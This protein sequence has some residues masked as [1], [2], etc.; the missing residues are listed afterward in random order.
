LCHDSSFQQFS[1]LPAS[2]KPFFLAYLFKE[3]LP[4]HSLI[5]PTKSQESLLESRSFFES[6]GIPTF[7]LP[8]YDLLPYEQGNVTSLILEDRVT[9]LFAL[10]KKQRGIYFIPLKSFLFPYDSL[11]NIDQMKV[12]LKKEDTISHQDLLT[13][14]EEMGY[15]RLPFIQWKGSFSLRGEI[16]DIYS[17]QYDH[18]FRLYFFDQQIEKIAFFSIDPQ[19]SLEKPQMLEVTLLPMKD[20]IFNEKKKGLL[21]EILR[22]DFGPEKIRA[23]EESQ[24]NQ[25]N[26]HLAP[27]F[28]KTHHI[29]NLFKE[30]AHP[31]TLLIDDL[32]SLESEEKNILREIKELYFG[33]YNDQ[34]VMV[35]PEEYYVPLEKVLSE[36]KESYLELTAFESSQGFNFSSYFEPVPQYK[37]RLQVLETQITHEF[38]DF[39]VILVADNEIH[40]KQLKELFPKYS[41]CV[42]ELLNW[43]F[44]DKQNKTIYL[45][46]TDLFGK[47]I[48]NFKHEKLFLESASPIDSFSD[49]ERGDYIVHI[50]H[51]IGL[52]QGIEKMAI[53]GS[54]K[55][56]IK[57]TYANDDALYIPIEQI[58]LVHKYLGAA[59]PILNSLSNK[60]WEQKKERV[61][62]KLEEMAQELAILYE[63]RKQIKGFAFPKDSL[64]QKK[65]EASFPYEETQGQLDAIEAIKNDMQ[66][67]FVMDRLVC[68][69]VGF[70]KTEVALRAIFKAVSSG[71]QAAFLSPTT[72]LTE[73]HYRGML[74]RFKDFS[75][76]IRML[77]RLVSVKD[78]KKTLED[79]K[80]GHI[81]IVVGTHSL[82]SPS[83][84]FKNLGLLVID[85]EQKFGVKH[86][87]RIKMFKQSVDVLTLS[88]TPIPRTLYMGLSQIRDMSLITTPPLSR[89]AI[90]T[91]VLPFNDNIIKLA[92]ERELERKGQVFI[93]HN[94]VK[95]IDAFASFIRELSPNARIAVGHAQM[96]SDEMEDVFLGFIAGNYDI[97]IATTIIEN[98]IDI[99]NANTII[100]D[101]PELMGL[102]DLY[103]LR[104][105]VG[106]GDKQGYAYL[107][108][109]AVNGLSHNMQQR[110]EALEENTQLG[111]GF[112]IAMRDLEIRGAGNLLGKDQSGVFEDIGIELYTKM[113]KDVT[114]QVHGNIQQQSEPLID[115]PFNAVIPESYI[116]LETERFTIYKMLMC[117]HSFEEISSIL[118][119]LEERYGSIPSCVNDFILIAKIKILCKS[120]SIKELK[121]SS[122][123]DFHFSLF[124]K[125][126]IDTTVLMDL[127][128]QGVA[129]L[130]TAQSFSIK[131]GQKISLSSGL[132]K[133]F[134]YLEKLKPKK[135][136]PV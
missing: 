60:K 133:L 26:I 4:S 81:D 126:V 50:Q 54:Q 18:P 130:K 77:S 13:K 70:G 47:K 16:L 115:I 106:R 49:L 114:D 19:I 105:R 36:K 53:L 55:D 90:K 68:G 41:T 20:F 61:R 39:E 134:F 93:V 2:L 15:K 28:Y 86:K 104:G 83:I 119:W 23:F 100:I 3:K 117:A 94:R 127:I 92:I 31:F 7:T 8:F 65:F 132:E 58:F 14:L 101:H 120:L 128:N 32:A 10:I 98:G 135:L 108:Y 136:T 9:S 118:E 131:M 73:Q 79:L 121:Y 33:S 44:I 74:E 6:L 11:L 5:V 96:P 43:G 82:L 97:L 56:Y 29:L 107:F 40:E 85:E 57:I 125:P 124:E 71:K 59:D 46:R 27:F 35:H 62:K 87:E 63:T 25:D 95:T 12:S 52:Y 75:I 45:T 109:D 99:S 112:K 103:Q 22:K 30:S 67:P 122:E 78:Q 116:P 102:S 48:K 123:N 37:G 21:K 24:K 17:P 84:H 129:S 66:S 111:S 64:F 110:L 88:A 76:N 42:I 80:Q 69:D 38:P 89:L 72:L 113:L 91:H 34:K 51:G 1:H